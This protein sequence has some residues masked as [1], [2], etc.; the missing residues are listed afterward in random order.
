MHFVHN[1]VIGYSSCTSIS[2]SHLLLF[3]RMAILLPVSICLESYFTRC[4][5]YW[6]NSLIVSRCFYLV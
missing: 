3:D 1:I 2:G 6:T 4:W 5:T